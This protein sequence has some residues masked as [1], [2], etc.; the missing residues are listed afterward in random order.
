M[1]EGKLKELLGK[2]INGIAGIRNISSMSSIG[3][4]RINVEFDLGVDL[5]AAAND[6]RD[7]VSQAR[8]SLPLDLTLPPVVSKADANSDA[9][10]SMTVQSNTKNPLQ[11]TEYATNVLVERLQTIKGV[12][13]VQI[14]GEKKFAM[15][16]WLDP[17]KLSAYNL[18]ALDV[19][20]ALNRENV[21]LPAGEIAGNAKGV[22]FRTYG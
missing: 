5:E 3:T 10:I 19:Q 6:V 16:I 9:I 21:E 11:L 4:S 14:W 15:R 18:T 13:S 17:S 7:K 8:G 20:N 1:V 2:A 12:S 22:T